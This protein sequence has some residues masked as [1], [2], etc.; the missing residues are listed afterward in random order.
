MIGSFSGHQ[1]MLARRILNEQTDDATFAL[2][3]ERS[4]TGDQRI[5][6]VVCDTSWPRTILE[7]GVASVFRHYQSYGEPNSGPRMVCLQN[8]TQNLGQVTTIATGP[9][10]A[11]G[12]SSITSAFGATGA[13]GTTG[14][15]GNIGVIST[16]GPSGTNSAFGAT[17]AAGGAITYGAAGVVSQTVAVAQARLTYGSLDASLTAAQMRPRARIADDLFGISERAGAGLDQF[18]TGMLLGPA[19]VG[20]KEL[21]QSPYQ[22]PWLDEARAEVLEIL[23]NLGPEKRGLLYEL[24]CLVLDE[25]ARLPISLPSIDLDHEANVELFW[26]TGN[27]GLLTIVRADRSLHFFGSSDGE[28]WRSSYSLSGSVWLSHLKLYLKPMV[29]NAE[30]A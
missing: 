18:P 9:S 16:T 2:V 28:S 30:R 4:G 27:A 3:P 14:P 23:D 17:G 26:R 1:G 19:P 10:G 13:F 24:T 8:S 6:Q 11:T 12:P 21:D 20:L 29:K 15:S 5:I 25:C 22:A 7:T